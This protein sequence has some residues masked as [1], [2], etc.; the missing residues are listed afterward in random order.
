MIFDVLGIVIKIGV[1]SNPSVG[2]IANY[3]RDFILDFIQLI[4][5]REAIFLKSMNL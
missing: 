2:E 1:S 5:K 4:L 3:K